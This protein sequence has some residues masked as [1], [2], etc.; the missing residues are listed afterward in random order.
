MKIEL[1]TENEKSICPSVC[2][3]IQLFRSGFCDADSFVAQQFFGIYPPRLTRIGSSSATQ[4]VYMSFMH[5]WTY[6]LPSL[7]FRL[8][9]QIR[10]C[11][12]AEWHGK[13]WGMQKFGLGSIFRFGGGFR[14]KISM[15]NACY[16]GVTEIFP[17]SIFCAAAF[18]CPVWQKCI[19][20]LLFLHQHVK[21]YN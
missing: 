19:R 13:R 21:S 3:L 9:Q 6:Q 16:H 18:S 7:F 8:A 20:A 12:G 10:F 17:W 4:L 1:F 15:Q 5:P 11:G 2:R 14:N